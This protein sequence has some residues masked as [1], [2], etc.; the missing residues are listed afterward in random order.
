MIIQMRNR[1]RGVTAVLVV[2]AALFL[3]H[4]GA[5][6][7]TTSFSL[8][9]CPLSGATGSGGM[10]LT[11]QQNGDTATFRISSDLP[12]A[13]ERVVFVDATTNEI[14]TELQL[15]NRGSVFAEVHESPG[16]NL[17]IQPGDSIVVRD[18]AEGI[19]IMASDSSNC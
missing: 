12:D 15:S 9:P 17:N 3:G 11:Q 10:T 19:V 6:A 8:T 18:A 7:A 16:P 14:V 1:A 2:G 13:G 5:Y 4:A